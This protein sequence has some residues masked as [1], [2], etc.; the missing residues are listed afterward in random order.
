MIVAI[1]GPA[2][3]GKSTVAAALA[4]QLRFGFLDTGA[5]YRCVALVA[6]ERFGER[7]VRPELGGAI[8]KLAGSLEIEL[9]PD[10]RVSVDG[11]DVTEKIRTSEISEMA[12][13]VAAIE[14]VRAALLLEQRSIISSGD[15]VVEGR[16][17]GTNIAPDA[18]V[19]VFLDADPSVRAGRRASEL[20]ADVAIV[21]AE[22]ALRD[23]RDA[24]RHHAPLKAAEDSTRIDTT[25]MTVEQV[26]EAIAALVQARIRR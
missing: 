24:D 23:A 15:W 16:D 5:M 10:F 26:V 11:V 6:L 14:G 2:G 13:T 1:D 7:A 3:A 12:S 22:Q 20:S 9:L 4:K 18:E 21:A 17:V 19:K 25:R 8:A